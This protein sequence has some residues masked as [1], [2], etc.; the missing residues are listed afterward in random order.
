MIA[1][2]LFAL[3]IAADPRPG[4]AGQDTLRGSVVTD[5]LWSQAL[6]TKKA[7]VVYLP[8]SYLKSP[9]RRYPVAYYL[10]G[11]AGSEVDW[12]QS[13]HLNDAMDSLAGRRSEIFVVAR[14]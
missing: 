1:A 7:V 11:L 6:G 3:S 4:L 12:T 13:G 9:A 8:P 14:R 10:H 5:T 2:L